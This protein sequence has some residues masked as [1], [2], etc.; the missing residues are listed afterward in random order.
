MSEFGK[1][2]KALRNEKKISQRKLAET[3]GIDFTYVSK[4]ESGTMDP[5]SEG[6]IIKLAKALDEDPDK[7]L[8]AAKKVPSD[9]Q[10]V[11]TE[12]KD[13]PAFLRKANSITPEQ[14]KKIHSIIE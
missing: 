7:M 11:I 4:I 3:V 2:L 6:T 10:K 1:I 5:P 14:W 12:N 13:V 8:L 9:F